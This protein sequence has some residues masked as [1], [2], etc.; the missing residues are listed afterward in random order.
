MS[1]LYRLFVLLVVAGSRASGPRARWRKL[2][3]GKR[4]W[5]GVRKRWRRRRRGRRCWVR[6]RQRLWWRWSRRRG[7]LGVWRTRR[8]Q[9]KRRRERRRRGSWWEWRRRLD[10]VA[11]NVPPSPLTSTSVGKCPT[12]ALVALLRPKGRAVPSR[13]RG[14]PPLA[15]SSGRARSWR[16]FAVAVIALAPPRRPPTSRGRY[17]GAARRAAPRS[18]A[19]RCGRWARRRGR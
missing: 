10:L 11:T 7:R 8:W 13:D 19:S 2:R 1:V 15:P 18:T 6:R 12:P 4:Q 3:G 16:C 17:S 14:S 5:L 9:R